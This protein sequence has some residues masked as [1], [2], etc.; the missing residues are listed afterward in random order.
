MKTNCWMQTG[1]K[2]EENDPFFRVKKIKTYV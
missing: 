2:K 1:E